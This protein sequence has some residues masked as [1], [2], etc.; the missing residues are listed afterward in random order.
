MEHSGSVDHSFIYAPCA[1]TVTRSE[2]RK[3]S[4]TRVVWRAAYFVMHG[5]SQRHDDARCE[6][7]R[8]MTRRPLLEGQSRVHRPC[9]A[10][11][12][13]PLPRIAR[14]RSE[15]PALRIG[16]LEEVVILVVL[17]CRSMY[18]SQAYL[19]R[20]AVASFLLQHRPAFGTRTRFSAR[21][22]AGRLP[23]AS[24]ARTL[25]QRRRAHCLSGGRDTY[26]A[27]VRRYPKALCAGL[28][29]VLL[30]VGQFG[31]VTVQARREQL[32]EDPPGQ[33]RSDGVPEV[34]GDETLTLQGLRMQWPGY[35]ETR[36]KPTSDAIDI[37]NH[38]VSSKSFGLWHVYF[39]N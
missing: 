14:G 29:G 13:H 28:G 18:P 11:S 22:R 27:H 36:P 21:W 23:L 16:L 34:I 1:R 3:G 19:A 33:Q 9:P 4:G 32:E 26:R 8:P 25:G 12:L 20:I 7:D 15:A 6:R 10:R 35:S 2:L 30:P 24:E 5:I 31:R 17:V 38:G 39:Y 37:G